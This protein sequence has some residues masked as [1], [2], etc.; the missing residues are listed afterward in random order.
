MARAPDVLARALGGGGAARRDGA[1]LGARAGA[2]REGQGQ[3]PRSDRGCRFPGGR[4]R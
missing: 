4:R 3:G 1:A 2:P